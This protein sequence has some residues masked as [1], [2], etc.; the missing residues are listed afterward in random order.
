MTTEILRNMLYRGHE[1]MRE[2]QWVVFDEVHFGAWWGRENKGEEESREKAKDTLLFAHGGS[3]PAP[4]RRA[5]GRFPGPRGTAVPSCAGRQAERVGRTKAAPR[6]ELPSS[7]PRTHRAAGP[8][9]GA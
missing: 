4:P 5:A 6:C 2:V 8:G 3:L 9:S 7:G 1:L